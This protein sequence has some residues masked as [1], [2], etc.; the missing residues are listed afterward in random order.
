[1]TTG[2]HKP[3]TPLVRRTSALLAVGALSLGLLL[4]TAAT[5]S[6]DVPPVLTGGNVTTDLVQRDVQD[7]TWN[8]TGS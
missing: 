4:G 5:A 6:A 2:T 1:M 8:S 3:A 7:I